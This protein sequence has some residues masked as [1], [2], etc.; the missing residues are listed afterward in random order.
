MDSLRAPLAA[1]VAAF[2]E[3]VEQRRNAAAPTP[4][5][6]AEPTPQQPTQPE[7]AQVEPQE[8][9][10]IF[11][12][13]SARK[14][15]ALKQ[16]IYLILWL[17]LQHINRQAGG[18][19]ILPTGKRGLEKIARLVGLSPDRTRVILKAGDGIWWER[20]PGARVRIFSQ[21]KIAGMLSKRAAEAG[22]AD[23]LE[24]DVHCE[25]PLATLRLGLSEFQG[26]MLGAWLAERGPNGFMVIWEV[27]G[28]LWGHSRPQ[29]QDW[30]DV[31]GIL[32]QHNAGYKPFPLLSHGDDL[33]ANEADLRQDPQDIGFK[34]S[35]FWLEEREGQVYLGFQR[36]NTYYGTQPRRTRIAGKARKVN[37]A[38]RK[39]A[40][41]IG[42]EVIRDALGLSGGFIPHPDPDPNR[43]GVSA[44]RRLSDVLSNLFPNLDGNGTGFLNAWNKLT[45]RGRLF[46]KRTNFRD[47][48]AFYSACQKRSG[49]DLYLFQ[50]N[51]R[52]FR[53][54]AYSRTKWWGIWYHQA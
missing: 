42:D 35:G 53:P 31:V 40:G 7:P 36:G 15:I 32:K 37:E 33:D 49:T 43:V 6:V 11:W 25:A 3:K 39:C 47:A 22:T 34:H 2:R 18:S 24:P 48:N 50:A 45:A 30:I 27:F 14:A 21:K 8:P 26:F 19:G 4:Q 12:L 10:V 13:A 46:L 29:M 51:V 23:P 16:T 41:D 9:Q 1:I 44:G 20:L 17:A 38:I 52:L 5:T 54:N 28:K